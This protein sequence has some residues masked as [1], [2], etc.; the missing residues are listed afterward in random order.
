MENELK[1]IIELLQKIEQK[2]PSVITVNS[3]VAQ[4]STTEWKEITYKDNLTFAQAWQKLIV[5]AKIPH[6]EWVNIKDFFPVDKNG[7]KIK[8]KPSGK[9][10]TWKTPNVLNLTPEMCGKTA[11]EYLKSGET[12]LPPVAWLY[13]FV[14]LYK[15]GK[16]LDEKTWTMFPNWRNSH[17]DAAYS[18]WDPDG[19]KVYVY[20][21]YPDDADGVVGPRPIIL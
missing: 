10:V 19:R 3:V 12:F 18:Y 16:F 4:A 8:E 7:K 13:W 6:Y 2:L 21:W 1:T 20:D 5:D 14:E 11:D 15:E 9:M 17:G